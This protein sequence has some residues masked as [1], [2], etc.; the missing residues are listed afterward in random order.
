MKKKK[1]KKK[2]TDQQRRLMKELSHDEDIP[3]STRKFFHHLQTY[4]Q[5]NDQQMFNLENRFH[6]IDE[7]LRAVDQCLVEG[8]QTPIVPH[9]ECHPSTGG[10]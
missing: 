6:R 3:Q 10:R 9:H 7:F 2:W 5:E 1:K 8:E 4:L